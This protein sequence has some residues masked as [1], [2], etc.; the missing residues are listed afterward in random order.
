MLLLGRGPSFPPAR[1]GCWGVRIIGWRGGL[2]QALCPG[3]KLKLTQASVFPKT[4]QGPQNEQRKHLAQPQGHR[5]RNLAP[6]HFGLLWAVKSC[7][8][9]CGLKMP[10]NA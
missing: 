9:T 4:L 8:R 2:R 10:K 3:L 5:Q 6:E 1:A 7:E